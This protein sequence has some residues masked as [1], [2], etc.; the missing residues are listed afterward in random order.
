MAICEGEEWGVAEECPCFYDGGFACTLYVFDEYWKMTDEERDNITCRYAPILKIL[1]SGE[2]EHFGDEPYWELDGSEKYS[3]WIRKATP[4][5][6]STES[7][8]GSAESD[9]DE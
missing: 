2:L 7:T 5:T 4:P 8:T 9:A 3:F 6:T 1:A